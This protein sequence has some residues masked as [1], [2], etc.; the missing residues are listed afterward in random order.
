MYRM[1]DVKRFNA[2]PRW[3]PFVGIAAMI[4]IEALIFWVLGP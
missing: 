2:H 4:V 1:E 3:T